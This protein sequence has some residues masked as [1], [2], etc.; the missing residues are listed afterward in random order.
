MARRSRLNGDGTRTLRLYFLSG[1]WE[2]LSKWAWEYGVD[3]ESALVTFAMMYAREHC[4]SP[5][6]APRVAASQ[7]MDVLEQTGEGVQ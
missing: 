4:Y 2:A 1:E 6:R 5:D 3:P 7:S